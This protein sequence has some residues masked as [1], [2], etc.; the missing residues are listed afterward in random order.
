VERYARYAAWFRGRKPSS[1]QHAPSPRSG[2]RFPRSAAEPFLAPRVVVEAGHAEHELFVT[3]VHF[4][5]TCLARNRPP[6][7]RT[8]GTVN[9][10]CP[11]NCSSWLGVSRVARMQGAGC[12]GGPRSRGATNLRRVV[13]FAE[14]E[15]GQRRGEEPYSCTVTTPDGE[16]H[17]TSG[18][19]Y[20]DYVGRHAA[21]GLEAA[22]L[23]TLGRVRLEPHD[24]TVLRTARRNRQEPGGDCL[25]ARGAQKV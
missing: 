4:R 23:P 8:L 19:D 2:P 22:P 21:D 9:C 5:V 13:I 24:V 25:K 16:K 14:T 18:S 12:E 15:R 3:H 20:D 6:A 17:R 7:T 11:R 10:H 1:H